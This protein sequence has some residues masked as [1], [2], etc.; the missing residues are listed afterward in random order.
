MAARS[1]QFLQALD[2]TIVEQRDT[3]G[4]V[5][6]RVVLDRRAIGG[7]AGVR[8]TDRGGCRASS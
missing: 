4:R 3:L 8:D 1:A 7:P 2:D 6:M 5:R